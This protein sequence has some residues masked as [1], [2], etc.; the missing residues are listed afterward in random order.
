MGHVKGMR[1]GLKRTGSVGLQSGSSKEGE[2]G[3]KPARV[4]SAKT[5]GRDRSMSMSGTENGHLKLSQ[6]TKSFSALPDDERAP[7]LLALEDMTLRE[8]YKAS[9]ILFEVRSA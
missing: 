6:S 1:G 5:Q 8:H 4:S 3:R 7:E 2:A 9:E